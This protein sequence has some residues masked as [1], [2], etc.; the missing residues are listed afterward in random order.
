MTLYL[1]KSQRNLVHT[2][3]EKY[4]RDL[5]DAMKKDPKGAE[6]VQEQVFQLELLVT[7]FDKQREGDC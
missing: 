5:K 2:A 7:W 3:L 4:Q 1:T 6:L